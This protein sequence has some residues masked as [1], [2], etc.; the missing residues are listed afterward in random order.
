MISDE[1][2]KERNIGIIIEYDV[3]TNSW[4]WLIED[5]DIIIHGLCFQTPMDA[6][7]DMN[8]KLDI[9]Y[10]K[11]IKDYNNE[12]SIYERSPHGVRSK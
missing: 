1:Y 3:I 2:I 8:E 4:N 6:Y 12:D 10:P 7:R 9:F 11:N 5:P